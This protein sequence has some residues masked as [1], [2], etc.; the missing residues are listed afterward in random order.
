[1]KEYFESIIAHDLE[2]R[3]KEQEVRKFLFSLEPHIPLMENYDQNHKYHCYDL[4]THTV[5]TVDHIPDDGVTPEE[6]KLLK[7][8]AFF[9]DVGKIVTAKPVLRQDGSIQ[10]SYFHHP[11]ES[12]KLA[13]PVLI[14]LGYRGIDLRKIRFFIVAHD[15]F[16]HFMPAGEALSRRFV[17]EEVNVN[18]KAM[19]LKFKR[20]DLNP[21]Y[22]DFW[23]L[24]HLSRSDYL[25]HSP[26][27]RD[28]KGNI[29]DTNER[30]CARS[31][32]IQDIFAELQEQ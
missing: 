4:L 29:R 27:V 18:N 10:T 1:M 14:K 11:E 7:T 19:Y 12:E 21:S 23:L 32:M 17:I 25:A 15:T 22:H 8:A 2:D 9:H 6:M 30:M 5:K 16:M 24:M 26:I 20:H 28:A 13:L 31:K 3:I